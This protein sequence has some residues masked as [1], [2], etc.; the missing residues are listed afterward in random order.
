MSRLMPSTETSQLTVGGVRVAVVRKNIKNLHVGVYPPSGR[1]RVAAPSVVSD[2][3]VRLAV[4][5]KL[6][7]IKRQQAAFQRQ[8]RQSEREAVSGESHYF[9]GRRYRLQVIEGASRASVLLPTKTRMELHV[10]A[11]ASTD[12][13]LAVLDNWYRREL[14]ALITP[15]LDTWQDRIGV[16]AGSWGVRRMKTKWGA[17]NAASS[18]IVLNSELAK[19]NPACVEYLLVHELI[20]LI[21]PSH[22]ERFVALMD[23]HMPAWR[24]RRDQLNAAPLAN[25]RWDY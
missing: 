11:G 20:H 23:E 12:R 7:W 17:C 15:L 14:S 4:I 8:P 2:E 24:A 21:E 1:V 19:K 16:Y 6:G 13:R 25:E 10:P 18:R 22:N 5:D 3:A 9:L